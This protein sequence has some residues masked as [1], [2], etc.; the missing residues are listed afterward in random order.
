MEHSARRTVAVLAVLALTMGVAA[1]AD[2]SLL[3]PP[4]YDTIECSSSNMTARVTGTVELQSWG[5]SATG[6]TPHPF[7]Q[8]FSVTLPTCLNG[9]N[10]DEAE[11][12]LKGWKLG[13]WSDLRL[14][15]AITISVRRLSYSGGVLTWELDLDSTTASIDETD[16]L[17][18]FEILQVTSGYS[19]VH[20]ISHQCSGPG[21]CSTTSSIALPTL[22][23]RGLALSGIT[24]KSAG[25]GPS[26]VMADVT[27]FSVGSSQLDS[28]M[29]CSFDVGGVAT[30]CRT[31]GVVV[32][33]ADFEGEAGHRSIATPTSQSAS[34][35]SS[36]DVVDG[37]DANFRLCGQERF[38]LFRMGS[39]STTYGMWAGA[40][41]R[42]IKCGAY[43]T[44]K[45]F[46]GNWWYF[47][48]SQWFPPPPTFFANGTSSGDPFDAD[49]TILTT[50]FY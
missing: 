30:D 25:A 44:S 3:I 19:E 1:T 40:T 49:A 35:T 8:V 41:D 14:E 34:K 15:S 21:G 11:I 48:G 5:N 22:K 16:Y 38:R 42:E 26:E 36:A 47:F 33:A 32:S 28:T 7:S 18:N 50:K 31:E 39:F 29:S 46:I 24:L 20:H 17:I 13:R 6:G 37:V 27:Q 10:F 9:Q 23:V 2:A 45:T 43:N 12:Y 4:T